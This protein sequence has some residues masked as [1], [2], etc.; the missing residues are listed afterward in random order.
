MRT[1]IYIL[2]IHIYIYI[3]ILSVKRSA[4]MVFSGFS[5][6]SG[7][8]QSHLNNT[9]KT[10]HKKRKQNVKKTK[11]KHNKNVEVNKTQEQQD[12]SGGCVEPP[13]D[14]RAP[15]GAQKHKNLWMTAE[16]SPRNMNLPVVILGPSLNLGSFSPG[17]PPKSPLKWPKQ[18]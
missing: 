6:C 13:V 2:C 3:Y 9:L 8:R 11:S 4:V 5:L 15:F 12:A 18:G 17:L 14:L 10:N 7:E 16:G 1:H